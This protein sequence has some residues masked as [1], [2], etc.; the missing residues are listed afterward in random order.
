MTAALQALEDQYILLTNN[1]SAL[2][3]ACQSDADRTALMTQYVTCRRTYFTAINQVFHDDDLAVQALVG[4][5]KQEQTNL[6]AAVT[7][8]GAIAGV[9]NAVTTAVQTGVALAAKV[10]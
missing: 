10:G 4:Q 3:A 6:A 5:M 8:I 7:H 9:I 2:Q 1:L